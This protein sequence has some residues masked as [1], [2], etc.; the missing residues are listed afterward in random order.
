[1][2]PEQRLPHA[3]SYRDLM[4]Y[5]KSR[6]LAQRVFDL[7][8]RF[9]R[10]ETYSLTDQVRRSSRS[11]GA[12]IAEAWA[13][14][15]YERSFVAKPVDTDGEL[16]ETQH[17]IDIAADCGYLDTATQES[18]QALCDAIGRM[19]GSMIAKS[20]LFCQTER[21]LLKETQA[22]YFASADP[23]TTNPPDDSPTD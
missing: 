17:W 8:R 5:A 12:Q 9:P 11:V 6:E 21:P 13:K 14:R 16:L 18:L 2:Q 22:E 20:A 15:P 3:Q 4:V 7:S 19:L 1:M 10:E 23:S